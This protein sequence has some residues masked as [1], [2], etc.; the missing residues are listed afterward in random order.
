MDK[1]NG[2]S[3]GVPDKLAPPRYPLAPATE[4][5]ARRR[6]HTLEATLVRLPEN[7]PGG[8]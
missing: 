2:F 5:V 8:R 7:L 4:R 1:E 3:L 6:N